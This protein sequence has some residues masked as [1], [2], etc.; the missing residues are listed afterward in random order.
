M[1]NKKTNKSYSYK[2]QNHIACSYGYKLFCKPVQNYPD[3]NAIYQFIS[4][5]PG[6]VKYCDEIIK[7]IF[8]TLKQLTNVIHDINCILKKDI[9]VR[10]HCHV[11]GK[12][13]ASASQICN[14]DL[15]NFASKVIR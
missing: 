5:M 6:Q 1:K 14:T 12:Y 9:R 7:S 11:T 8:K 4:N 3:E 13:R 15:F 2:Y 10:N